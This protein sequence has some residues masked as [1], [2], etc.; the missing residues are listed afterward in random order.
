MNPLLLY[1]SL[2]YEPFTAD[3]FR[4]HGMRGA[5]GGIFEGPAVQILPILP[6]LN[7]C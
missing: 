6:F 4:A 1:E 5:F 3:H 2:L 7:S